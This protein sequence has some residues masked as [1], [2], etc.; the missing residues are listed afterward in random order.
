MSKYDGLLNKF[1]F[2]HK[3]FE[4]DENTETQEISHRLTNLII[5][6]MNLFHK[7][8]SPVSSFDK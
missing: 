7:I 1:F 3:I 5:N 8:F 6:S 4:I 2:A